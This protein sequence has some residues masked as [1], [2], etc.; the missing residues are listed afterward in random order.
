MVWCGGCDWKI[1]TLVMDDGSLLF[2]FFFSGYGMGLLY[3]I[4]IA[5]IGFIVT[6]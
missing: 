3:Y 1:D 6:V 4:C 2:V 5:C